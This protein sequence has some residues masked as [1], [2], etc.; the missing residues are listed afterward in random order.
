[1]RV[2]VISVI[3]EVFE[4]YVGT[5]M[6]GIARERGALEFFAHDLREWA[7]PGVHRQV[8]DSPYGG[9]CGMVL[10]PEPYFAAVR[11]VTAMDERPPVRILVSP[12][13]V[14]FDQAMA[15]R[16]AG[17]ERLIIMCGRYEGFD[18]RIRTLADREVSVGDFVLTGGELPAMILVDAVARLL[19]GVL[20]GDAST[21]DESFSD[22][23]LEYP[24]YTRPAEFEGM[25]VPDVLLSGDHARIARWRRE[26]SVI[27]TAR[28]RPDLITD[29]RCDLTESETALAQRLIDT[30]TE[31][32]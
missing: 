32:E 20:G 17:E 22:G 21:D 14:P 16:L 8:D 13:G 27:R 7:L 28:R 29:T 11:A 5:S 15:Q 3:P 9:G 10:R 1:M 26:Q 18:E 31:D 6:L 25:S 4:P 19:P 12:Q 23:L 30:A 2:D 24:H